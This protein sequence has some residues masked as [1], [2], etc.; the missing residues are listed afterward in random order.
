MVIT[1]DFIDVSVK[2]NLFP[3]LFNK[4]LIKCPLSDL[5]RQDDLNVV[6]VLNK[7]FFY[8]YSDQKI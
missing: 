3:G 1:I 8:V 6:A 4:S 7:I 2:E 5:I